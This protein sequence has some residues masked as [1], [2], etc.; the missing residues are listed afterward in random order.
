MT[1]EKGRPVTYWGGLQSAGGVGI[2]SAD[3]ITTHEQLEAVYQQAVRGRHISEIAPVLALRNKALDALST[4]S[5]EAVAHQWDRDG[6]RC[7]KCGAKDWMAGEC[8]AAPAEAVASDLAFVADGIERGIDPAVC[9]YETHHEGEVPRIILELRLRAS[10]WRQMISLLRGR[11]ESAIERSECCTVNGVECLLGLN[12][13]K[14]PHK[15]RTDRG[16]DG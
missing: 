5:S 11:G 4:P 7:V 14:C 15:N 3:P 1:D 12:K 6:E 13:K 10:Q 9:L 2:I 16:T 8:S